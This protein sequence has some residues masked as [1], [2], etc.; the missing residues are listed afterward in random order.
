M[1]SVVCSVLIEENGKYLF[2]KEVKEEAKDKYGLPGGRLDPGET[3]EEA[4]R[5][6]LQEE[7]GYRVEQLALLTINQ[8]P[9]TQHGNTVIKF[10]YIG[11]DPRQLDEP[12]ELETAWLTID[13]I[14]KYAEQG[15]IRGKEIPAIIRGEDTGVGLTI[16]TH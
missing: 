11:T 14:K 16:T 15:R 13:E 1:I 6:E 10:V 4:A 3:L 5:R 7:A 8:K 12:H 2:V 9:H